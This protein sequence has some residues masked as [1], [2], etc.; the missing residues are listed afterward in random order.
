MVKQTEAVS[1]VTTTEKN[2]TRAEIQFTRMNGHTGGELGGKLAG[3]RGSS[4]GH[5]M[6]GL[7]QQS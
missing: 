7:G 1:K 4:N 5:Q 6:L 3:I 2:H